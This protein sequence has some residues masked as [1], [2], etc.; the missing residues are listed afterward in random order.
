MNK[1]PRFQKIAERINKNWN[2]LNLREQEILSLRYGLK[3]NYPHTLK[4]TGEIF[5]VTAERIR[6]L[7]FLALWKI[8]FRK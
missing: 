1:K 2:K 8:G 6:Q 5:Q 3:D 4:E 7:E